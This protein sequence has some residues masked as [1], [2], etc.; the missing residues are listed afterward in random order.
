MRESRKKCEWLTCGMQQVCEYLGHDSERLATGD[1][2]SCPA[3]H[4][5]E[6]S[7]EEE[8]GGFDGGR[9]AKDPVVEREREGEEGDGEKEGG[10]DDVRRRHG[11]EERERPTKEC[12]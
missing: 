11:G 6:Y 12:E 2:Q 9:S 4:G 5:G 10:R 8:Y 1:A 7:Q 3:G